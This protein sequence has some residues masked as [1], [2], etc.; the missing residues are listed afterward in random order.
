[1]ICNYANADMV[2]HTGMFDA[3]VRAIECV[4]ACLGRV[5]AATSEA[6]G[7]V[8]ITADHGNA[9]QMRSYIPEKV[10]AEAHTAHTLNLVPFVYVGRAARPLPG[11]GALC[12][13]A[14]TLLQLM[15]LPQPQEMT[16]RCLFELVETRSKVVGE[17]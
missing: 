1:I 8:L 17:N 11:T 4:D 10:K 3:A 12:D 15:G 6:G 13:I 14:P 5:I 9:E 2:G 16:G 7:E